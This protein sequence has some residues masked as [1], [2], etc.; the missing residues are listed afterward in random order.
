MRT[1]LYEDRVWTSLVSPEEG[2]IPRVSRC[3]GLS[4][5]RGSVDV[6]HTTGRKKT[7]PFIFLN[8]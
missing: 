6:T 1:V 5:A 7:Q 2:D 8:W 4:V 3:P